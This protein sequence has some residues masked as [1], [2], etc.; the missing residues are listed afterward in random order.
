[1][2]NQAGQQALIDYGIRSIVDLRKPDEVAMHPNPFAAPS[3]RGIVYTNI[4][5]VDPA[6]LSPEFTTLANDYKNLLGHFQS[7]IGS[8]IGVIADAPDGGVLVHC[9]GGKDRTGIISALLLELTGVPRHVIGDDYALTAECLRSQDEVWL[10]HGPGD[11]AW[12]ERELVKYAPLPEVMIEVLE[13][14]DEQYDGVE[15]YLLAAG[16]TPE[17]VSRL[18]RRLMPGQLD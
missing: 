5:L 11:R 15:W 4:S 2:L 17:Q 12:R 18:R 10:E 8:I 9:M 6:A 13:Y 16:V 1:L 7:A 14:L 3:A